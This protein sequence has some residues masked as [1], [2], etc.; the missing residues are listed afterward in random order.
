[1][2]LFVRSL[3]VLQTGNESENE[4]MELSLALTLFFLIKQ[5]EQTHAYS[6]THETARSI[7]IHMYVHTYIIKCDRP[8]VLRYKC[9]RKRKQ[10]PLKLTAGTVLYFLLIIFLRAYTVQFS[11]HSLVYRLTH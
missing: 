10:L 6:H 2:C 5:S 9:T 4:C 11:G 3:C 7:F 1:M 8:N